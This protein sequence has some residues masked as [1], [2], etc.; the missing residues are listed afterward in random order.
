MSASIV[1]TD[2]VLQS[3]AFEQIYN[4]ISDLFYGGIGTESLSKQIKNDAQG[5]LQV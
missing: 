3:L 4:R 5:L 2:F 1:L